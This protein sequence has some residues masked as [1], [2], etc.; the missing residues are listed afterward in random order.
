VDIEETLL[1]GVGV[2][3]RPQ[4]RAG[5]ARGSPSAAT[6][7]PRSGWSSG[8]RVGTPVATGHRGPMCQP[9]QSPSSPVQ[10]PMCPDIQ[11]TMSR[12]HC[13]GSPV[14]E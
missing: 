6:L 2:L 11:V 1:P 5:E 3:Y 7:R 4:T 13:A 8:P 10:P 9:L 12:H 14:P